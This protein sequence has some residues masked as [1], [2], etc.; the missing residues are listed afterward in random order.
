MDS[1]VALSALCAADVEVLASWADDET[2]CAHAGWVA[3]RSSVRDF[4]Q[5]QLQH[6]S[7][8]LIRL[9][10]KLDGV[11]VGHIDLHGDD[12]QERELGYLIGPSDRWGQGLGGR[13]AAAG[14][15]YAFTELQ[16]HSVWAEAV[17]ANRPSV[18]ILRSCGMRETGDG[19]PQLSRLRASMHHP[20]DSSSS[21]TSIMTTRTVRTFTSFSPSTWPT[22]SR[23]PRPIACTPSTPQ[24]CPM[25]Q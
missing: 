9:G 1:A 3:S 13:V 7:E 24:R 11:L 19:A 4:W 15:G 16:L 25:S 5:R 6:P 12:G 2:F 14:L 22:C 17:V 10:A 21:S 18:R 23:R 8:R 20:L